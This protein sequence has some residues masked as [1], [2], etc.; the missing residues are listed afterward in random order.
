MSHAVVASVSRVAPAGAWRLHP[1]HAMS[2]HPSEASLLRIHRGRVWV[3]LGVSGAP[4]PQDSGDRF[5]QAGESL[6][7]PPGARLVMEPLVP[8]GVTEPVSFDWMGAPAP[9]A[10]GRFGRD[11]LAPMHELAGALGLAGAALARVL[12]GVLGYSEF[13]VAGRGRVLSPLESMRS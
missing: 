12:R 6:V 9:V 11:V 3:T 4:S 10:A 2:L 1:G 5:L 8:Q 7:V 13:L